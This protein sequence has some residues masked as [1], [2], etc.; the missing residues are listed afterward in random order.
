MYLTRTSEHFA[1]DD[2]SWLGSSHG[3]Q[4]TQTITLD[5]SAFVPATHYPDGFFKS[6]LAL[7]RITATG[8]YGPY[9]GAATD[10]RQ[11]LAGFLYAAVD[12]PPVNTID[13]GAA[14]LEHGRVRTARLPIAVDAAGQADA[15]GRI[16]F[17]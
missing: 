9:D 5:T 13:V 15:A 6:G 17:A 14:I 4:A 7:G 16:I 12:A 11:N 10:G 2:Q 1:N 8:L 3:T